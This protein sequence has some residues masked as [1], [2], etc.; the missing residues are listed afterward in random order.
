MSIPASSIVSITPGV[1]S[2]GGSGLQLN[3]LFLDNF[4]RTPIGSVLS[5]PSALAVA[6]YYGTNSV[7]YSN[8]VTYFNGFDNSSI[9]PDAMWITQY[10]QSAVYPYVRGS[11]TASIPLSTLQ[12]YSGTIIVTVNGIA[13]TSSSINLSSA[14]SPSSAAAL[15]TT[16][17]AYYDAVSGNNATI[18]AGTSTTVT[19]SITGYTMNVTAVGAGALKVGGLLS[20]SGV[21]TGTYIVS[22][23]SGTTGGIGV[24]T[25]NTPTPAPQTVGSTTITQTYGLMTVVTPGTGTFAV[26]QVISGSGVAAGSTIT[27]L[28]SGTGQAGTYIISGGSQTV[29]ATT[30]SGGPLVCTFDS[31][32]Q[33]YFITGGTPGSVG[34]ISA[35]TGTLAPNIFLTAATGAVTSQGAAPATPSAFMNN[36]I[37]ITTDWATFTTI[38][39]PDN[40]YGNANKQLFA[41]WNN[42]QNNQ[43]LYVPADTDITP[44]ESTAATQSLGYILEANN[45]S[46]TA[47]VYDP[48]GENLNA[49]ICG[50][51][52]SI[53]YTEINGAAT[54]AFKSQSGLTGSVNTQ[55]AWANLIANSYNSYG[56]YATATQGF[57]FLYPGLVTGEFEWIDSYVNQ[58]WLNSNLQLS[59]MTLLTS[60]R[61]VPYD[62]AGYALVR[63]A[64]TTVIQQALINGVINTGV[65][66]DA[67]QIAEVNNAAGLPIDQT[68][69]SVG[70]YLQILPASAPTRNARQSPPITLWYTSAGSIQKISLSSI[71]VQ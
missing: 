55:T 35:V 41:A 20:G 3:G 60:A 5:F 34:T 39:D 57:V 53:D 27:A 44:T 38:F 52:A 13:V 58:I 10:N 71:E 37:Q 56:N 23:A 17:L 42:G 31:I 47:P 19:A 61:S 66:L 8:A 30:I 69:S 68:L 43:F 7:I 33:G 51:V 50:A 54:L 64:C 12:G 25:V 45:T 59:L 62:A 29:S 26:G 15:I 63:A 67:L 9:N 32:S 46:G 1:L 65:P 70:Y 40:G 18:A 11:S 48:T 24:Y 22:Q 6:N 2:P 28:G 16:G 21:T 4:H 36:I 14:T 49:F